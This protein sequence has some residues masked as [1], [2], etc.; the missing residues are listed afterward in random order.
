[1]RRRVLLSIVCLTIASPAE[2]SV[3][4]KI[5]EFCLKA[6]DFQGCVKSM[7]GDSS[8]TTTTIRQIQQKG[9]DIAEGNQCPSGFAYIGGGNCQN[10]MCGGN[11]PYGNDPRLANKGWECK[12]RLGIFG[13]NLVLEGPLV[14]ASFNS[15]CPDGEPGIGFNST[16][17]SY[18]HPLN[19]STGLNIEDFSKVR[20]RNKGKSL[21]EKIEGCKEEDI[22]KMQPYSDSYYG[23]MKQAEELKKQRTYW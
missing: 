11:S 22:N 1:M 19:D 5:A 3:D 7:S 16:C 10:V 8:G 18:G 13:A 4:P 6:Q 23:C 20:E 15:G 12:K 14:R 21:L 17:H 9:A 2:A